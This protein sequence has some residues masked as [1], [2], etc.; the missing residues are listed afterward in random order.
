MVDVM[1][2]RQSSLDLDVPTEVSIVGV[3]GVGSW[4]AIDLAMTGVDRLNLFDEDNLEM[5][6]LNR[7]PFSPDDV[8]K[9]KTQIVAD[10]IGKI[11]PEATVM[12]YGY[13]TKLTGGFLA[14]KV[15]DCTDKTATQALIF[16]VCHRQKLQYCRVGYDGMHLTVVDGTH[17]EA[18]LPKDVW[19]D[20]PDEGYTVVPSWV[21]PP[22]VGAALVTH[23]ICSRQR[24]P[25]LSIHLDE[26]WDHAR[27]K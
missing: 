21:V 8:G 27:R 6:N 26:V 15:I 4:V 23:I 14:G 2:D 3:G 7:L 11:R 18:I 13:V 25:T 1:Y 10:F 20:S 16:E 9:P 24:Y 12:Q 5:H 17:P 22:Q 19:G